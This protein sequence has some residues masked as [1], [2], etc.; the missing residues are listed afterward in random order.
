MNVFVLCA[1]RCGSLTVTRAL[2]HATNFTAGHETRV[3]ELGEARMAYPADHIEADNRL[4]WFIGRLD[5]YFGQSAYYVHLRRDRD[6]CAASHNRRWEKRGM[7][8]AY[9]QGLLNRRRNPKYDLP[10][11]Y[12]Y[13]RTIEENIEFFLRD[14]PHQM[15][16]WLETLD[17]DLPALWHW[18]GAQGDLDAAHREL[19]T[20]H[21]AAKRKHIL[22][23]KR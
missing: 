16:I 10:V 21:N 12:D 20:P 9:A 13:L 1:G 3:R 14:K 15:N 18:I 6:A 22:A 8:R 4:A 5:A 11:C 17:H 7:M 19:T 23:R 2:S